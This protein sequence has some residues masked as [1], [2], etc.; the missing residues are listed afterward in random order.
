M[1]L[2]GHNAALTETR[3]HVARQSGIAAV[4]AR[5]WALFKVERTWLHGPAPGS[6]FPPEGQLRQATITGLKELPPQ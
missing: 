6:L 4:P 5:S 3:E 1:S 2:R